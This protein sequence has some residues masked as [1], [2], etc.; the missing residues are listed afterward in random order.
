[1]FRTCSKQSADGTASTM[2]QPRCSPGGSIRE[3]SQPPPVPTLA[4]A[5]STSAGGRRNPDAASAGSCTS[6]PSAAT[7]LV[8]L[9][10]AENPLALAL[11]SASS[12]E[13]GPCPV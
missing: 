9:G 11:C 8:C 12:G 7:A 4:N 6:L 1:M 5:S 2:A 3:P 13:P 10:E